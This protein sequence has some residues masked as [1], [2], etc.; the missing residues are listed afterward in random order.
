MSINLTQFH[1]LKYVKRCNESAACPSELLF[2]PINQSVVNFAHSGL[3][4]QTTIMHSTFPILLS[5]V[6]YIEQFT[7][8]H[9]LLFRNKGKGL[10][11]L[12]ILLG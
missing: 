11:S 1:G 6:L 8:L 10:N 12:R 4:S 5:H 9:K 3:K 7:F 2:P